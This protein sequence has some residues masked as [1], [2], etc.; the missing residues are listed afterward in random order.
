VLWDGEALEIAGGYRVA[1]GERVF[2]E[3]G[4]AGFYTASLFNYPCQLLPRLAEGMEL[5]RSFVAPAYQGSRSLDYLWLGIGAYLR[6]QPGV[7]YLFGP[8]SISGALPLPAREQ[9]VAYYSR[10][11]G[12]GREGVAAHQPFRF[13]AAPPDFGELGA[14][15]AF[16][17]LKANLGALGTRVPTLYKQ[18]TELCEPGGARFLAF[19]VD[20]AFNHS[21]DGLIEVDLARIRARKRERYLGPVRAES[22]AG[23]EAA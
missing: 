11:F 1:P 18:Y 23:P 20:P 22:L 3:R 19:G 15:E 13:L 17:L 21:V 2:A 12:D 14:D 4:L 9:M 5:G 16:R 8:V 7:R 10:Y 6:H